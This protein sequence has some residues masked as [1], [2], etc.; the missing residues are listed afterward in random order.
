MTRL[1]L[2][3]HAESRA[4][5]DRVVGGHRG[6]RG[7]TEAGVQQAIRLRDR[8][9]A[10]RELGDVSSVY[11]SELA[12]SI[13]T[14]ELLALGPEVRRECGLCELH[15]G[16]EAD[17]LTVSE[18]IERYWRPASEAGKTLW[19]DPM[20]PG[21]ESMPQFVER[22]TSALHALAARHRD[23]TIVLVTS[24]GPIRASFSAFGDLPVQLPFAAHVANTSLTEWSSEPATSPWRWALTSFNDASH[25]GS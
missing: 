17:G 2:I 15:D 22:V 13:E 8:L 12:R 25:L 9:R 14:A 7:L 24:A 18:A 16:D 1:V 4:S 6:C 23:E 3:R 11:A 19:T 21:G 5:V 10:T 20:A